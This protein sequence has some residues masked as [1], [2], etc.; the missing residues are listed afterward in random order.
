MILVIVVLIV[1]GVF[2]INGAIKFMF[3]YPANAMGEKPESAS[4]QPLL[5][6]Y[7]NQ[8]LPA[9]VKLGADWCPPCRQMKPI[10]E[11][12]K[13]ELNGKVIVLDLDI[14]KHKDIAQQYG[15]TS[16]PTTLF[17]NSKGEFKKKVVGFIDKPQI[18]K[19]LKSL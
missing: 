12:L 1:G 19:I 3:P 9:V 6:K 15:I 2:A 16:I 8:G 5:E 4:N 11:E 13:K 7:L 18:L 17:F 14:E 10:I